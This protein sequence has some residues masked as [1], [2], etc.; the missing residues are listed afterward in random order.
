MIKLSPSILA[1]DFSKV[2]EE[3]RKVEPYCDMLHL[4]VMD[5]HFV[6]NLS[7][8]M[9]FIKSIREKTDLIFD[10]H[11]MIDNP[12][13]FID[14]FAEAGSDIITVHAEAPDDIYYCLKYIKKLG[15]RSGLAL[16]P[17]TSPWIIEKY[18]SVT[19]MVLQMTVQPGF[20]G[21]GMVKEALSNLPVIRK[22]IGRKDL[23]VDGGIYLNNVAEVV[24]MGANVIVS[25]TGIFGAEDPGKAVCDMRKACEVK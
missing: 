17:H 9:Y 1:A 3:M 15:L 6:P 16:N 8:G 7:F 23:E 12:S 2:G 25:G 20:G 14:A 24:N 19:D 4:D 21:Q 11:L 18:L 5:G 22:M 13:K 10:T